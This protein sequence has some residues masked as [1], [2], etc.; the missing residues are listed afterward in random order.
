MATR[1]VVVTIEECPYC[2]K[3]FPQGQGAEHMPGLTEFP[4]V[5]C[6]DHCWD[7]AYK[8]TKA[9]AEQ[10]EKII[11]ELRRVHRNLKRRKSAA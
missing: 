7:R 1:T 11:D 6:S 9:T 3:E 5:F 2:T 4:G 10:R 8:F